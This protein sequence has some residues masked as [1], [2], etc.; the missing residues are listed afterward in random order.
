VNKRLDLSEG[1]G[2]RRARAR[3]K[4]S[5]RASGPEASFEAHAG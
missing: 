4:N 5:A 3:L 2:P 1:N